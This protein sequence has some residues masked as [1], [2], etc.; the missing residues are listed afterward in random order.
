[1]IQVG[2]EAVITIFTCS[3]LGFSE[4]P[5]SIL[6]VYKVLP[7]RSRRDALVRPRAVPAKTAV[8]R[9]PHVT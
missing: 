8:A 9:V 1:M 3:Q 6:P 5:A 7:E 2:L 4:R